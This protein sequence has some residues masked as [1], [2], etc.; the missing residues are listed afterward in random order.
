[1][2]LDIKKSKNGKFTVIE[3]VTDEVV[4]K[5][6]TEED[7]K[8]YLFVKKIWKFYDNMIEIDMEFPNKYYV[9]GEIHRDESKENFLEWWLKNCKKEG[10]EDVIA[11]KMKTIIHKFDLEAYFSPLIK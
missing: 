2:G 1:M 5:N 7:V 3:S 4:I 10:F 11:E 9:N 8:R 6:G